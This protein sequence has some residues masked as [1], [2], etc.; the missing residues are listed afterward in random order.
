MANSVD[1]DETPRSAASHLGLQCL[2]RPTYGK[3]C[4]RNRSRFNKLSYT[5]NRLSE[6]NVILN[7]F[8]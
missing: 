4:N 2:L 1:P 7:R 5:G 8:C 6:A 3:Y